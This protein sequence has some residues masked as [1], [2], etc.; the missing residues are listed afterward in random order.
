MSEEKKKLCKKMSRCFCATRKH[1]GITQE[2]M[3]ELLG[4]APRSYNDLEHGKFLCS[5]IVFLRY[6]Q[7]KSVSE[8]QLLKELEAILQLE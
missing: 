4:I 8:L 5:T 6:L 3:A 2:E 1:L 7:L